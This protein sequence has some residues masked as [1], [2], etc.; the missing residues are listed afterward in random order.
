MRHPVHALLAHHAYF[1]TLPNADELD[2]LKL[3]TEHRQAVNDAAA[4]AQKIRGTG[5]RGQANEYAL[6]AAFDIVADLPAEQRD[7][8]YGHT[9]PL[10]DVSDPDQLAEA[11]ISARGY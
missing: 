6:E 9:D 11:V 3:D 8:N 2:E 10:A 7:P 4:E 1:G 5:N